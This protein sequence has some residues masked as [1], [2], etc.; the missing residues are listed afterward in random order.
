MR[1]LAKLARRNRTRPRGFDPQACLFAGREY[2]IKKIVSG[3]QTG[4]DRAALRVA[5][6]FGI[7]CG[8]WCPR[9]RRAEDGVIPSAFPLQE[10]ESAGY[11]KRTEYNIRDSDATLIVGRG[12]LSGGSAL[13]E[14][15]AR[16]QNRPLWV[17]DLGADIQQRLLFDWLSEGEFG[18]LNVAG[19]RESEQPGIEAQAYELLSSLLGASL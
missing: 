19:P 5:V 18:V 9:G 1:Q 7:P 14:R 17:H 15:I 16:R 12:A 11:A 3:G 13:T 2:V 6:N 8:G 4:V 10:T